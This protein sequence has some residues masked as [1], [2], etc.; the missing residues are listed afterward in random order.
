M[1]LIYFF[2]GLWLR[3]Y[4]RAGSFVRKTIWY[5]EMYRMRPYIAAIAAEERAACAGYLKRTKPDAMRIP[6]PANAAIRY[7]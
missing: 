1:N 2:W 7:S 4:F 3:A 5:T 6:M